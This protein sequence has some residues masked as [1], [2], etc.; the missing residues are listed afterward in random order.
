MRP[1][2]LGAG[3]IVVTSCAA[4][5][6]AAAESPTFEVASV[7]PAE[8][9][10]GMGIRVMMRGGPGSADPGQLTYTNVTLKNVLMNAYAVKGYQLNGPKWLDSERFDIVAK[11]PKA[12]TKEQFQLMLQNLLA[13]RFKLTLHHETKDLPM[14]ALVVGKG[15]PKLKE[16]VEDD[17]TAAGAT[18]Q[19]GAAGPGGPSAFAPPPPP[20]PPPPGSD[21][22]G[23]V[24]GR[25]KVG[26][27]GMPQLPAGMGKNNMMMIVMNGR[28]RLMAS[29]RS[30]SALAEMLGNQLGRPV[31]DATELKANYDFNLDFA[32]DGMNGPMGMMP[33]PPP[34]HDGG[35]GGGAPM[36]SASDPGGPSI[37]TALQEQLGLK[38]EQRK[39]PVDLLVIDRLEKA[40]TEN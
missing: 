29:H 18:P 3:L 5:G 1:A 14:Y 39:G 21:G 40:P 16:S 15:G 20:P 25:L 38:L 10:T 33:P 12:A 32:P 26:A 37:F 27:D 31:V 28:M 4:F 34:Q 24:M 30:M 9:Q 8:P 7:K 23:P 36:A 2:I 35:P 19:G 13:E 11:I 6:Q 17:A 22:A